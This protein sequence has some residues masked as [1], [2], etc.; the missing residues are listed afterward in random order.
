[1]LRSSDPSCRLWPGR[2]NRPTHHKEPSYMSSHSE[3]AFHDAKHTRP[4]KLQKQKGLGAM[5]RSAG[6]EPSV[7]LRTKALW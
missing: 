7:E 3:L 2:A 4:Q 1:M 5:L 6:T